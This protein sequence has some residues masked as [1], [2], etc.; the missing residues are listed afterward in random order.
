MVGTFF[1]LPLPFLDEKPFNRRKGGLILP[2]TG[3]H[4]AVSA[5]RACPLLTF[6]LISRG[7]SD[8]VRFRGGCGWWP[9]LGAETFLWR[10]LFSRGRVRPRR[11][12]RF[13]RLPSPGLDFSD[14]RGAAVLLRHNICHCRLHLHGRRR[15]TPPHRRNHLSVALLGNGLQVQTGD[16][17]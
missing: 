1:S 5:R 6:D 14:N 17:T 13:P 15:A 7:R 11:A 16:Y 9:P 3:I 12:S 4:P 8:F 10:R 2:L